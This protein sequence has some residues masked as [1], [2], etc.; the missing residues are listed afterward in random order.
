MLINIFLLVLECLDELFPLDGVCD[1][2][3]LTINA[4]FGHV[5]EWMDL[6]S[7]EELDLVEEQA[8]DDG[9]QEYYHRHLA[10]NHVSYDHDIGTII[11]ED[12]QVEWVGGAHLLQFILVC[13]DGILFC[14][15][16]VALESLKTD[17]F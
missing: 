3:Q 9:W 11:A 16:M 4:E 5:V 2:F 1:D 14:S 17:V 15:D 12:V 13:D 7:I 10:N 8:H 6:A